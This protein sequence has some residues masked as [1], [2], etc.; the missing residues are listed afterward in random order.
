MNLGTSNRVPGG[1]FCL[2][3]RVPQLPRGNGQL[4]DDVFDSGVPVFV[5]PRA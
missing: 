4:T 1:H 2:L 5:I 3:I